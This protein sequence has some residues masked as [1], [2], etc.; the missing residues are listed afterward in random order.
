MPSILPRL[1]NGNDKRKRHKQRNIKP[2][3]SK[4]LFHK[5]MKS[6]VSRKRYPSLRKK[7]SSKPSRI[8]SHVIED[9]SNLGYSTDPSE[10]E[11]GVEV[12][13]AQ[14]NV[15]DYQAGYHTG[16]YEGGEARVLAHIPPHTILPELTCDDVIAAGVRS[17][18]PSFMALLTAYAVYEEMQEAMNVKRPLSIVRLGDGELLALAAGTVLSVE[19]AMKWGPFLPQA[20]YN[21]TDIAGRQQ[22]VMSIRQANII[23]VPLSRFPTFQGLLFP[24]LQYFSIPYRMLRMTSSTLNYELN[25]CKLFAPLLRNRRVIIV[26]NSAQSLADRLAQE[27]IHIVGVVSPVNG[28]SHI[29][30][31]MCSIRSYDFD[32][33]L[34]SAGIPAV[35]ICERIATQMG[36]VALDCGHL[37]NKLIAN[38]VPFQ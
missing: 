30:E 20:G 15:E 27:N 31:V 38:E 36:R 26:G 3:S 4:K 7:K 5:K 17:L 29:E 8:P 13:K 1:A 19:E 28:I 24:V 12:E 35:I 6:H 10:V 33:A 23:G 16:Y 22:L 2:T 25:E 11:V 9:S 34:V 37:A 14:S 18:S 32:L 21:M